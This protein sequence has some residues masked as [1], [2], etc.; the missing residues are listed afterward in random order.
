M[1]E[2]DNAR[3]YYNLGLLFEA[4]ERMV[5]ARAALGKAVELDS[6]DQDARAQLAEVVRRIQK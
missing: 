5:E 2:P 4:E 3:A 1:L 6:T